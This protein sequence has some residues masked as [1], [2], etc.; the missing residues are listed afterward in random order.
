[1][2]YAEGSKFKHSRQP[3]AENMEFSH[4]YISRHRWLRYALLVQVRNSDRSGYHRLRQAGGPYPFGSCRRN[5]SG[6]DAKGQVQSLRDRTATV[7]D[8][9]T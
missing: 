9:M 6:G 7:H 2:Q 3:A 8:G 4:R 5:G 1:M